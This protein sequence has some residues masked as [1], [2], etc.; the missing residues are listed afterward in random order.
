MT[1][2]HSTATSAIGKTLSERLTYTA[3]KL[4][5][6]KKSKARYQDRAAEGSLAYWQNAYDVAYQKYT[7]PFGV[8]KS[9]S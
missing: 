6:A 9:F 3:Q 2:I 1:Q 7:N 4:S 8:E 5:A